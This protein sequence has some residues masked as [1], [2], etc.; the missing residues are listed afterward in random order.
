MKWEYGEAYKRHPISTGTAV[1]ADGSKLKC[2]DIFNPLPSFMME[3][4][5]LFVDSPWNKG[6]LTSFYTKAEIS[7]PAGDYEVFYQRLFKCIGEI[8]PDTAYCEIGKEYLADFIIEMRRLYKNVV[9]Y[10][11]TYYHNPANLC[12]VVCG[13]RKRKRHPLDG[14]DEE[15]IIQWVCANED[16]DCIADVC[17]GRGLVAVNAAKNGKKFV[18]TELNHKRLSVALEN[19]DK[20]GHGYKVI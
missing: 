10:N 8:G 15:N 2:H 9:F 6:N 12:Y 7:P 20:L 1:F 18:G 3:A 19:L 16:Y 13:S 17:M 4:D 5:L 14:M 11:S